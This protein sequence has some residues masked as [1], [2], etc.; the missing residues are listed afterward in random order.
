VAETPVTARKVNNLEDVRCVREAGTVHF[1]RSRRSRDQH[2]T[3][4]RC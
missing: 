2:L 1:K 3:T 4:D